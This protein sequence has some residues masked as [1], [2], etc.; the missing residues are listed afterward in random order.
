[1]YEYQIEVVRWIDG[2]T[3]E[4]LVDLGFYVN[5][6][7]RFRIKNFDTPERGQPNFKEATQCAN[8]LY[9]LGT[10]IIVKT[11]KLN[12][13]ANDKYGRYLIELPVLKALLESR[14]LLKTA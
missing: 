12:G 1:M 11:E 14:D 13:F 4:A 5:L 10:R 2:D 6:L 3:L 7:A 8:E 9:P